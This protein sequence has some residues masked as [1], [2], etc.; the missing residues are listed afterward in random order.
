MVT[1]LFDSLLQEL[2]EAMEIEDLHADANNTCLI[3]FETSLEVYIE[4][5]E[6]GDFL[7]ICTDLGR[8]PPGRYREDVFREALKSNGLPY[9]RNGTFGYS[10]QSDHLLFF[11]LLSLKEL[12]GEKIATF[13]YPF[14]EKALVW[15]QSIE[16]G[17][18]PVADTMKTGRTTGPAG[19]FG[20]RP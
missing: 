10:E 19:L 15:K 5:H 8:V 20:L 18:V 7:L 3:V 14:M 1:D 9:P 13:L 6:K 12:N 17:E 4:P 2:G 11:E 16:G